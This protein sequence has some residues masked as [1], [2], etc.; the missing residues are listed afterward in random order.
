MVAKVNATAFERNEGANEN[1][2]VDIRN[3]VIKVTVFKTL[4][5]QLYSAPRSRNYSRS[6]SPSLQDATTFRVFK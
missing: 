3:S 6:Y 2:T 4:K 1:S 5:S